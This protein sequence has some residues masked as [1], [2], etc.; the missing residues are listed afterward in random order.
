MNATNTM[1]VKGRNPQK[2]RYEGA[3]PR[4]GVALLRLIRKFV[5]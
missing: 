3:A 2:Q 4:E 1:P 5:R